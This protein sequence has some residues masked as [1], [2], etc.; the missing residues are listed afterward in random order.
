MPLLDHF[1]APL[2]PHRAWESFHSRWAN[3]IADGLNQVLPPRYF[4][5][6]Q[7]HLGSMV[8]ADVAEF[9]TT[10]ESADGNGPDRASRDQPGRRPPPGDRRGRF[11]TTS[12]YMFAT[13]ARMRG[14]WPRWSW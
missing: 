4:T 12:K 13:N 5:E 9:E 3:S 11:P 2:Y 14:W 6:V 7:I 8:E 1:H 10:R